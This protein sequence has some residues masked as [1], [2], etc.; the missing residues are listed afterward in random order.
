MDNVASG[1]L[2]PDIYEPLL[3]RAYEEMAAHY[4]VLIDP[5]RKGKPKDKPRVERAIPYVRDS[6]WRG[7]SFSSLTEI[8]REAIRWCTEIAGMRIHGTTRQKPL[9]VFNLVE[10]PMLKSLPERWEI[11]VWQTAKVGPDS[12]CA[13]RRTLYSVPWQYMGR[14]LSVRITDRKA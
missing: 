13:V 6:F 8:N 14:E 3:N 1:V 4:G 7:R 9:E 11:A 5:C 12:R 2:K 10:K